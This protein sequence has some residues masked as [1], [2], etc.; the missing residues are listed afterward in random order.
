MVGLKG[1]M[2][3]WGLMGRL[4][5]GRAVCCRVY[6]TACPPC[7]PAT[8]LPVLPMP[9]TY[10][11]HPQSALVSNLYFISQLLFRRYGGN[12]IVQLLGRWQ[13]CWVH[14]DSLLAR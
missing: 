6:P 10:S 8:E 1:G 14:A 7:L 4:A 11:T 3:A 2:E 9:C 5:A 12:L 13:V